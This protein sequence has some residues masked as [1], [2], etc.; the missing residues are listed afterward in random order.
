VRENNENFKN[1]VD[2]T[3]EALAER[4]PNHFA[5]RQYAKYKLSAGETT[6]QGRHR[7]QTVDLTIR[8]VPPIGGMTE[9]SQRYQLGRRVNLFTGGSALR[10][11][12]DGP[13]AM[14]EFFSPES[15]EIAAD[16]T[17][18][19]TDAGAIRRISDGIV[20]TLALS[21]HYIS[22]ARV[23]SH[24]NGL[25]ILTDPWQDESD[26][27]YALGRV[28]DQGDVE[29]LITFD[30]RHT[31]V[32]DFVFGQDGT[33]Y[34]IERNE[35]LGGVFLRAL[36]RTGAIQTLCQLQRGSTSLAVSLDGTIYIGNAE[37]GVIYVY[38]Q[39]ELRFFAGI[40]GERDFIDGISPRFYFPQRLEYQS[41]HLYVWD[42]NTLRRIEATGAIPGE[43]ISIAGI[44]SPEYDLEP[45]GTTF[46]AEDVVLPHG[47]LMDFTVTNE[48]I[49]LTDHKRGVVWL[50]DLEGR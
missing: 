15:V 21:P 30:A 40:E 37:T 12:T 17:I 3:F 45:S 2:L 42:F 34:F 27:F 31:A 38:H 41:G 11:R 32:E 10:T 25:Y 50:I 23:R 39:E 1:G 18:Y 7:N 29:K 24:N 5:V 14:A 16:G 35:G 43:A 26:Y 48:G 46:A 6:I 47:R 20:E 44:A 9:I 49:L 8:V 33:L 36:D 19:I 4:D 28:D 13:L 22:A